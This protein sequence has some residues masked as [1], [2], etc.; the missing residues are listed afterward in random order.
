MASAGSLFGIALAAQLAGAHGNI[1]VIGA[2]IM[3]RVVRIDPAGRD[4]AVL[5]GD[6][7]GACVIGPGN[8]FAEIRDCLLASDGEFAEALQLPLDAPLHMEGRTVILHAARK[9]PRAISELLARNGCPPANVEAY[10]LHQANLNLITRVAGALRVP[11]ERFFCNLNRY[12]NTSAASL[13][14]A[15]DEWRRTA[16]HKPGFPIVFAAF[17]AGF[18]WGAVL[19]YTC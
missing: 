16:P 10:L 7:A 4:T 18:H 14:I 3:S 15:T 13:L 8:G 6:G 2:E 5:F 12:G 19:A 1:L 11:E 17:G 9:L